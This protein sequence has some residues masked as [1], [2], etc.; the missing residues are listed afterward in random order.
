[1]DTAQM[2]IRYK[3]VLCGIPIGGNEHHKWLNE[4]RAVY[5]HGCQGSDA[6]LSGLGWASETPH[7]LHPVPPSSGS[8]YDDPEYESK[9]SMAEVLSL[10]IGP[11]PLAIDPEAER[12]WGILFHEACWTLL[13]EAAYPHAIDVQTL[14]KVCM[15]CPQRSN[16]VDWGHDYGG[17][18]ERKPIWF[19]S[20]D[21]QFCGY[22]SSKV[23]GL[24]SRA[25][26]FDPLDIQGINALLTDYL[27]SQ[28]EK[29]FCNSNSLEKLASASLKLSDP[30]SSLPR[31]IL[32]MI[33]LLPSKDVYNLK[34]A[35]RA[36][37]ES[38]L[39]QPFWASRFQYGFEYSYFFEVRKALANRAFCGYARPLY[40]QVRERIRA[41]EEPTTLSQVQNRLR[42]WKLNFPLANLLIAIGNGRFGGASKLTK[43]EKD[44]L[45]KR[46]K[47]HY[48]GGRENDED[49]LIY[50]GRVMHSRFIA[51]PRGFTGA[52]V[53]TVEMGARKWVSGIRFV[54]L[55][56]QTRELGYI[57]D[58]RETYL[59]LPKQTCQG[60]RL[61]IG[62]RVYTGSRCLANL[63]N[64]RPG[65]GLTRGSRKE[66]SRKGHI[67]WTFA[68]S[69]FK[70]LSLGIP[71]KKG[72][73][74]LSLRDTVS[75]LPEIP[76]EHLFL[77]QEQF[78]DVK[79]VQTGQYCQ[80]K[81]EIGNFGRYD[82]PLDHFCFGGPRGTYLKRIVSI[83]VYS[84]DLVSPGADKQMS[85]Q[86]GIEVEYGNPES[87]STIRKFGN[88]GPFPSAGVHP[89]H[90]E[91][92]I[93][94]HINGAGGEYITGISTWE[95][96]WPK[97]RGFCLYTNYGQ[98]LKFPEA[99]PE[100]YGNVTTTHVKPTDDMVITGF[101]CEQGYQLGPLGVITDI[102]DPSV[103]EVSVL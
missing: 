63:A 93:T 56:G 74:Q 17:V 25:L 102:K 91:R 20:L 73:K 19:G 28:Q 52:Y 49:E 27:I 10:P 30:F 95:T 97:Q 60:F 62:E 59:S 67:L 9:D 79:H 69:A 3:Y 96:D 54:S 21:T 45:E 47:W 99:R 46:T 87:G 70:L 90:R 41:S 24:S 23:N 85:V 64:Y 51:L 42:I 58:G 101:Y 77:N 35:S 44:L 26:Q 14:K 13:Q 71:I 89:L 86:A 72:N 37:T 61:A 6:R 15:S 92:K 22:V 53:S 36:A 55:D 1:M 98:M 82:I 40:Y 81:N 80:G 57:L 16:L 32:D 18:F 8:R 11:Y 68:R 50:G 76:P 2:N 29:A 5:T 100:G 75:W 66:A 7:F 38:P 4:Y 83:S 34:L 84:L 103:R 48:A 94:Y 43:K 33:C 39:P 31:E 65:L 12:F 88:C 78:S